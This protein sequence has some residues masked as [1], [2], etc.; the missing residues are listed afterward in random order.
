MKNKRGGRNYE[1]KEIFKAPI[2]E[3]WGPFRSRDWE[4]N[5]FNPYEYNPVSKRKALI[6][7][8][9]M[10][11]LKEELKTNGQLSPVKCSR[12]LDIKDYNEEKCFMGGFVKVYPQYKYV[13]HDGNHR[14][15]A[16][17]SLYGEEYEIN[18]MIGW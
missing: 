5:E 16:L 8:Y 13:L 12:V 2:K 17:R 6:V 15:W 1:G 7:T 3:I 4:N 18:V 11:K 9:D 10:D 14:M